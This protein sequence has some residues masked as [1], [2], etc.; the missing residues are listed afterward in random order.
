ML[1]HHFS[2]PFSTSGKVHQSSLSQ[3][4][5]SRRA[6][7]RWLRVSVLLCTSAAVLNLCVKRLYERRSMRAISAERDLA[8]T[9]HR[10]NALLDAY[11]DRSSLEELETAKQ[12]YEKRKNV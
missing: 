1:G 5:H 4:R 10:N 3:L 6:P 8:E 11:G 9:Q 2:R 12:V 7:L